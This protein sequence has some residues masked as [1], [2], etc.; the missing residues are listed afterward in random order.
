MDL[1]LYRISM[2]V[3]QEQNN[4]QDKN[5][6]KQEISESWICFEEKTS[7][8]PFHVNIA[9]RMGNIPIFHV[10]CTQFSPSIAFN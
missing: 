6:Q 4:E 8:E 7:V 9:K 3:S 5:Y 10:F 1:Q 2:H